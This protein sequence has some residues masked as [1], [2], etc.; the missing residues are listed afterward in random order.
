MFTEES[1]GSRFPDAHANNAA[2]LVA[3]RQN[4][5]Q[6][7]YNNNTHWVNFTPEATDR[8]LA[9]PPNAALPESISHVAR[10]W[11]EDSRGTYGNAILHHS[12]GSGTAY[13]KYASIGAVPLNATDTFTYVIEDA[14]GRRAEGL[15]TL[16]VQEN[17]DT[18]T[19][20]TPNH[21]PTG[22]TYYPVANAVTWYQNDHSINVS[23]S[24]GTAD[25]NFS[26]N[27]VTISDTSPGARVTVARDGAPEELIV[28]WAG[29]DATSRLTITNRWG[30]VKGMNFAGHLSVDAGHTDLNEDF[31]AGGNASVRVDNL[32]DFNGSVTAIGSLSLRGS[33]TGSYEFGKHIVESTRFRRS[34][35]GLLV[36]G[37]NIDGTFVSD[38]ANVVSDIAAG[39]IEEDFALI[40]SDPTSAALFTVDGSIGGTINVGSIEHFE[41][42]KGPIEANATADAVDFIDTGFD[43]V[44]TINVAGPI[45]RIGIGR[46]LAGTIIADEITNFV[47][48]SPMQGIN[49]QRDLSGTLDIGPGGIARR[50]CPHYRHWSKLYR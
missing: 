3:V 21:T 40:L 6:W 35:P 16:M 41:A 45:D 34:G 49:I 42:K 24:G 9:S 26:P 12:P 31:E 19:A 1:V 37:D 44:G 38:D 18:E 23:V 2:H 48:V 22:R 43:L 7:Q 8:L 33:T 29:A 15:I 25:L 4:G 17:A 46:D 11:L 13:I 50:N 10:A 32:Y 39:Q 36:V 20:P 14:L 5:A 30:S 28:A 47:R 27:S